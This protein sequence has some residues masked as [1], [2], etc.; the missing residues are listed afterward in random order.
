MSRIFHDD[1]ASLVQRRLALRQNG[2][3]SFHDERRRCIVQAKHA[4]AHDFAVRMSNDL[5]KIQVKGKNNAPLL[6]R[7]R[8]YIAIGHAL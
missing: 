5:A 3:K 2:A 1:D 8:E 6:N 4:D 7:L